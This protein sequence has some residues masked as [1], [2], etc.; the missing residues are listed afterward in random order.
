VSAYEARISSRVQYGKEDGAVGSLA[1]MTLL[2]AVGA[3]TP[4]TAAMAMT[5]CTAARA[6]TLSKAVW[7]P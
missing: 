4:W 6:M 1:A 2:M 7:M 5:T 3:L